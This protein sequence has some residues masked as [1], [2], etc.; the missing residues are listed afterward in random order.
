[1]LSPQPRALPYTLTISAQS[2]S[3]QQRADWNQNKQR[4]WRE[5]SERKATRWTNRALKGLMLFMAWDQKGY[6]HKCGSGWKEV[7][8]GELKDLW[9]GSGHWNRGEQSEQQ[10]VRRRSESWKQAVKGV[11]TKHRRARI[12]YYAN[13]FFAFDLLNQR[14]LC[15]DPEIVDRWVGQIST[16][17]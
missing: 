8:L 15:T 12:R 9:V 10:K 1:M 5:V 6:I 14:K 4:G 17:R 13:V 7:F 11:L 2:L 16:W 3:E